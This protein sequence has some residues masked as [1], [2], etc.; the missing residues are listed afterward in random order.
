MCIKMRKQINY[1]DIIEIGM[2][3]IKD[4]TEFLWECNDDTERARC[5]FTVSGIVDFLSALDRATKMTQEEIEKVADKFNQN[6][7][8]CL[9]VDSE[10][11]N[12]YND[13]NNYCR[14]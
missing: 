4:E 6:F 10:V 13:E 12:K 7:N 3:L 14:E 5:A 8:I 9:P 2:R 11:L 1:E